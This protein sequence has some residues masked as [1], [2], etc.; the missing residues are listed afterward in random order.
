MFLAEAEQQQRQKAEIRSTWMSRRQL[1]KHRLICPSN[2]LAVLYPY[3]YISVWSVYCGQRRKCIPIMCA[4]VLKCID[5][6]HST[7]WVREHRG[8]TWVDLQNDPC[9]H[10]LL[11]YISHW[12]LGPDIMVTPL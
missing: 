2:S 5:S 1:N 11:Y 4:N 10:L 9:H 7:T 8:F 3:I 6:H 12:L